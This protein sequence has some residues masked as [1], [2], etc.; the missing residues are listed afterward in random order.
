M[1]GLTSNEMSRRDYFEMIFLSPASPV[2]NSYDELYALNEASHLDQNG[3]MVPT[4]PTGMTCLKMLIFQL[5]MLHDQAHEVLLSI[6]MTKMIALMQLLR[7]RLL[8]Q[9]IKS[10]ILM[11]P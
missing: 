4:I 8:A 7:L 11:T 2:W 9:S 10:L 6:L 5:W 3:D 1:R